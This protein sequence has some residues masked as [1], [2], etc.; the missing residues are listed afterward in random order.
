MSGRMLRSTILLLP[1]ACGLLG[2]EQALFPSDMPR[3]Q[4]ERADRLRG[5]YIPSGSTSTRVTDEAT[6]RERLGQ[7]EP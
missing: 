2:C 5:R 7:R 4:Y 3:T 1:L 6:L